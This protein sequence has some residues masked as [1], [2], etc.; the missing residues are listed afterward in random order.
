MKQKILWCGLSFLLVAALVLASCGA[1]VTEKKE[2]KGVVKEPEKKAEEVEEVVEVGEPQYGGRIT[3]LV[4]CRGNYGDPP[5]WDVA[6]AMWFTTMWVQP[7]L[8]TL[9][10][11]DLDK[12]GPRGTGE[13]PFQLHWYVPEEFLKGMLA[14]SWEVSPDR[15]VFHI[16]KGVNWTGNANIGMGPRELTAEDVAF[17]LNRYYDSPTGGPSILSNV[18][19]IYAEGDTVVVETSGYNATW[20]NFLGIGSGFAVIYPPEMV[21]AGASEWKNAVGTGPFI[22]TDYVVGSQATWKRNPYYWDTTTI[23]GKEYQLPFIDE[24]V[25]PLIPDVATQIAALRTGKLDYS[26]RV[27]I[28]YVDTLAATSPDLIRVTFPGGETRRLALQTSTSEYF[29]KRDVRRAMMIGTD[30]EAIRNALWPDG[31]I[32]AYPLMR[33]SGAAFTPLEELPPEARELYD[34]N[35]EKAKQMLADAGYPNGFEVEVVCQTVPV[36]MDLGALIVDQWSRIGVTVNLKSVEAAVWSNLRTTHEYKDALIVGNSSADPAYILKLIAMPG[37]F[38]NE[39]EY[40][41]P[42]YTAN[43]EEAMETLDIAERNALFKDAAIQLLGDV[44]Y[45]SFAMSSINAYLWPWL[46]NHHGEI[47]AWGMSEIPITARMWIDQDLKKEMG[48]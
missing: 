48:Y 20:P 23:N 14:E 13:Y 11:G 29:T 16:R 34:Y 6:D 15:I 38:A 31:I 33:E 30:L 2:V 44:A 43:F 10:V 9:L 36:Q 32:H 42:S 40:N 28:E 3:G 5:S 27:A 1:P 8:E 37:S 25:A 35:P 41:E 19:S 7:H 22:L 47:A 39:A 21:E 12:Y 24:F 4:H 46:K 26:L 17:S 18:T 45:I